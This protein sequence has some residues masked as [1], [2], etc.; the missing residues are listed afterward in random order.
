MKKL[1]SGLVNWRTL[2]VPAFLFLLM[3]SAAMPLFAQS[4]GD[5]VEA[6]K[7]FSLSTSDLIGYAYWVLALLVLGVI[8]Y[9]FDIG[10]LSERLTG[11]KVIS[12]NNLNGWLAMIFL[13]AGLG[14]VAYELIYHGKHLLPVSASEHGSSI[15]SMFNWTFGFT[16]VVFIITEVL[17]FYFMYRYKYRKGEKAAYFYHNNQLEIIWTIVPAIVL[18]FLVLRGYN[19]WHRITQEVDPKSEKIEVFGYQ[20]GWKAR[21]AGTDNTFGESNYNFID[22]AGNELGLAVKPSVI[23]LRDTLT[24]DTAALGRQL[25][26]LSQLQAEVAEKLSK[27]DK[28]VDG[29]AYTETAREL[30]DIKNG[31]KAASLRKEMKRKGVQIQRIN[32]MLDNHT[33]FNGAANDDKITTEIHLIKGKP[34]TFQFR[35]RDVIHSAYM[36][37][38]RAQMNVVPGMTTSFS[39][40]PSK[41][42][43]E[44]RDELKNPEFH[45]YLL[46]AKICG[47][48]HYN[49]KIKV[50]VESEN[51]YKAWLD[52]QK[53][54]VPAVGPESPASSSD[55]M[56]SKLPAGPKTIAL[57]NR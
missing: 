8:I 39:M 54:V 42:T 15:D 23:A 5:I 3:N 21:Y 7:E 40:T 36:P 44:M 14:G 13:I 38:F 2:A 46:C 18:T 6:P 53:E 19:T 41:T 43:E 26:N 24:S 29:K 9:I 52:K 45:Y 1:L 25:R 11:K 31:T 16:F 32:T 48:A 47:G 17:L 22:P 57:I 33:I 50:V 56:V 28:D 12:W 35:A 37:Y 51:E 4:A 55:S 34:Y 49:M 20:F 27:L 30:A 10:A